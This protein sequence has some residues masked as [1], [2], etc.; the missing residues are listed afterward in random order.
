MVMASTWNNASH[1]SLFLLILVL[2]SL[3]PAFA[4][5]VGTGYAE[6]ELS[7]THGVGFPE[8]T[9]SLT[10]AGPISLQAHRI[11]KKPND[12]RVRH[13]IRALDKPDTHQILSK[14][15]KAVIGVSIGVA[16]LIR[17]LSSP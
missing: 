1:I 12:Q 4:R 8:A 11:N 3:Q 7:L 16:A 17:E 10:D 6:T 14:G 2:V 9:R 5:P 15:G 13:E